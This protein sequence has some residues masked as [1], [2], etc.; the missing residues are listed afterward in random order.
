MTEQRQSALFSGHVTQSRLKPRRHSLD[1]RIYSLLI[2]LDE[3]ETL[4][5]RLKLFSVD[6]F[7]LFS[8]FRKDRGDCS[9]SDLNGHVERAMQATGVEPDG[10]PICLLIMPRLLGC[11][12]NPL[13]VF[14]CYGR[15]GTL[16]AILWEKDNIFCERHGSLIPID[17]GNGDEGEVIQ[18]C[19]KAF[20]VSP[21]IDMALRCEFRVIAPTKRLSIHI[22]TS[23][24]EG[25][26]LTARHLGKRRKVTDAALLN[27]CLTVLF[28]TLKVVAGI[29]GEAQKVWLKGRRLHARPVLP[30]PPISFIGRDP[31]GDNTSH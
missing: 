11:A 16:R 17:A 20:H 14:F 8:F 5:R 12:F 28:L 21:F 6:R 24:A 3:L 26:L 2:D 22:A 15:A 25:L 29:H 10:G 31:T 19:D 7:N 27:A 30:K 1:Y 4:Q 18:R 13:S 9:G 23:D